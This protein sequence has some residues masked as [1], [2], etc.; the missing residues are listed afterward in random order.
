MDPIRYVISTDQTITQ[1]H[2]SKEKEA[3]HPIDLLDR[4][5]NERQQREIKVLQ[6]E[7]GEKDC[8]SSQHI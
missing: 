4:M 3:S 5:M 8:V 6:T 7:K 1:H 2:K